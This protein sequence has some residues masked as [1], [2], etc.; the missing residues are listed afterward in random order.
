[1]KVCELGRGEV[2]EGVL[3]LGG[4]RSMRGFDSTSD[5]TGQIKARTPDF[6]RQS[7]T[8]PARTDD[9]EDRVL[10]C[11]WSS[12]SCP[13][14]YCD[15]LQQGLGG[16]P[17]QQGVSMRHIGSVSGSCEQHVGVRIRQLP[18]SFQPCCVRLRSPAGAG[19]GT[20]SPGWG[21]TAVH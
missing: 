16:M 10:I 19:A 15:P 18:G 6:Y 7:A 11:P 20:C 8:P 5:A 17:I 14:P 9:A 12:P 1:M 13:C 21:G 3:S 2:D 4:V